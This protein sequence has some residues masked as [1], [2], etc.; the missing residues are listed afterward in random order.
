MADKE[1]IPTTFVQIERAFE[2]FYRENPEVLDGVIR[3][4]GEDPKELVSEIAL[5]VET[6][7]AKSVL[8][9][10][11]S[12]QALFESVRSSI[13]GRYDEWPLSQLLERAKQMM[14]VQSV[15]QPSFRDFEKMDEATLRAWL[16][17]ED[18]LA[19]IA[20]LSQNPESN[21]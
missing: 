2:S 9:Q 8:T 15:A 21:D 11:K 19:E 12:R 16:E 18:I 6:R 17:N 10:A 7:I 14:G 1:N 3:E 13:R 5:R 4:I 20:K